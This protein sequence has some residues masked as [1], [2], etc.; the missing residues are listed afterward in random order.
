MIKALAVGAGLLAVALSGCVSADMLKELKGDPAS[1][2]IGVT[3]IYGS[4]RAC[5]TGLT[6]VK[7]TCNV[8]G[9][10]VETLGAPAAKP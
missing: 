9:M 10:T 6:N 7:V 5:R 2:H 1:V 4:V 3:S 8:D